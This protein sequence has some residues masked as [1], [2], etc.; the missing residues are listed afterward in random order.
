[1]LCSNKYFPRISSKSFIWGTIMLKKLDILCMRTLS[2][3]IFCIFCAY[4]CLSLGLNA[5]EITVSYD[6]IITT[7]DGIFIKIDG[8]LSPFDTISY[9]GNGIYAAEYYGQCGRCGWALDK[10]GKCT[11]QNC[12]Q[13]GPRE[14][15]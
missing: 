5:Q 6:K 12:N 4:S 2:C 14:R 9:V 11:N 15:D 1:M 10:T 7:S 3:L 13:Y 8:I